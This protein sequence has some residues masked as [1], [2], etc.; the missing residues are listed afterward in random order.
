MLNPSPLA[1][2]MARGTVVVLQHLV[3]DG[4]VSY[5]WPFNLN[6][7]EPFPLVP[8]GRVD[9]GAV[10]S[11]LSDGTADISFAGDSW[12]A[13]NRDVIAIRRKDFIAIDLIDYS[14]I[15]WPY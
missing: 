2:S 3:F 10:V 5:S 11:L 9:F 6:E 7:R 14:E 8:F 12:Q 1:I 13:K 15:R 4:S